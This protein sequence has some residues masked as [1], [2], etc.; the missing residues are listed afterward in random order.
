ML[1]LKIETKKEIL[2]VDSIRNEMSLLM[3][4]FS[5]Y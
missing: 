2:M 4:W 5:R 1:F 3:S